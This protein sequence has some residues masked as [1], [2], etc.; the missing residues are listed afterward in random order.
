MSQPILL[1]V[2]GGGT[3]TVAWLADPT[4]NVLGRGRSG[5]SNAKAVGLDSA[6][7]SLQEAIDLAFVDAGLERTP[8]DVACLGL[9][10]WDRPQD[11]EL[12]QSWATAGG[13]A[14]QTIAVNDGDL[15]LAA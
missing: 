8:A 10:G 14:R 13:W 9:A 6:R 2:D 11:R 3:T 5:P 4:G 12:L 1:G 15:L 7:R